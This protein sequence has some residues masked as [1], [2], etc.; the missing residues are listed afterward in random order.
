MFSGQNSDHTNV[1]VSRNKCFYFTHMRNILTLQ[2]AH[3]NFLILC[4]IVLLLNINFLITKQNKTPKIKQWAVIAIL[5]HVLS[6]TQTNRALQLNK[7]K[8]INKYLYC[9]EVHL[10]SALSLFLF[11][12]YTEQV[13][14][15]G[16]N[17]IPISIDI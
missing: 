13:F 15:F 9:N 12:W 14:M 4:Q 11:Q 7:N 2:T 8:Q 6:F 5:R 17:L 3:E 10:F 1:Q 16:I